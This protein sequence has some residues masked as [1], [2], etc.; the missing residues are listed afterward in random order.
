[1]LLMKFCHVLH[2]RD[3][4]EVDPSAY[5]RRQVRAGS[6]LIKEHSY[7]DVL[8]LGR[9]PDDDKNFY[10]HGIIIQRDVVALRSSSRSPREHALTDDPNGHD[11]ARGSACARDHHQAESISPCAP[12][13]GVVGQRWRETKADGL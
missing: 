10:L 13:N 11:T 3:E 6:G 8:L 2:A 7:F 12:K 9:V 4:A 5:Q 1:M